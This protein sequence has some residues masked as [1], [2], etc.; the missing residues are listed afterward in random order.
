VTIPSTVLVFTDPAYRTDLFMTRADY[1]RELGQL[2]SGRLSPDQYAAER[3]RI[4]GQAAA[5]LAEASERF[6]ARIS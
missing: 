6:I 4:A 2:N 5:R 3:V 1:D